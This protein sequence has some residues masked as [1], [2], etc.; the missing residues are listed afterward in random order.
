MADVAQGPG[1]SLPSLGRVSTADTGAKGTLTLGLEAGYGYTG[2]VLGDDDRHHR[3]LGTL[4]AAYRP[5]GWL[6]VG[7][8]LGGRY[9]RHL[10]GDET[11][12]GWV[13]D[14]RLVTR[15]GR[16]VSDELTLGAQV[17]L[18]LPGSRAPS[19]VLEAATPELTA[20]A[21][22]QASPWWLLTGNAGIRLDRSASS[23]PDAATFSEAD[24]LVLGV[25]DSSAIV[26]GVGTAIDVPG[27]RLLLEASWDVLVGSDAPPVSSYPL[28]VAAGARLAMT[29]HVSGQFLVKASLADAPD[30]GPMSPLV[31]F[32][33]RIVVSVGLVVSLGG[34]TIAPVRPT[35][36]EARP[37]AEA[38][39]PLAP[40]P[41]NEPPASQ[42]PEPA[43][44][45]EAPEP[46]APASQ[47]RG[48][49]SSF[50][51]RSLAATVMV[52]DRVVQADP[53]GFFEVVLEPGSYEV[54]L[55]APGFISQR[56]TVVIEPN[57][58][59]ILNVDLRRERR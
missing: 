2:A 21:T 29:D 46:E 56:K 55:S 32:D 24:R 36:R 51:G 4:S 40:V 13:G 19:V 31:P 58:V 8:Q 35:E 17:S 11:D 16:S 37:R 48:F 33:P 9:D 14:P 12:D 43:P 18:W 42:E 45:I 52:D 41:S 38:E 27:A 22:L 28:R 44:A 3:A 50:N 39:P 49:V 10:L 26:L 54:E 30:T 53:T 59:T 57:G 1:D 47:L 23:A 20:L 25:S 34:S 7:L 15:V 6:A 5:L